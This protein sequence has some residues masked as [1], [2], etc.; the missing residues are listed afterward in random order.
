VGTFNSRGKHALLKHA[1]TQGHKAIA[2]GRQGRLRGQRNMVVEGAG[3][4]E[5]GDVNMNAAGEG[6]GELEGGGGGQPGAPVVVS[7]LASLQRSPFTF[8]DQCNK[9][10]I[11]WALKSVQSVYSYRFVLSVLIF[12]TYFHCLHPAALQMTW[13]RS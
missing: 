9:A 4:M 8:N 11:R 6:E 3:E 10:E 13:S 5:D 1:D 2:D 7:A 12:C